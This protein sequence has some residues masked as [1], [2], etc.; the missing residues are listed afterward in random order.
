[1]LADGE[2]RKGNEK[3]LCQGKENVWN[4]RKNL[5]ERNR[6][7]FEEIRKGNKRGMHGKYK[8]KVSRLGKEKA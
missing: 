8:C 2:E 7:K 1:M 6:V 4:K 3:V 5:E